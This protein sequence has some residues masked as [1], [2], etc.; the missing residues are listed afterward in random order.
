MVRATDVKLPSL[1]SWRTAKLLTQ[2]Q[3]ADKSGV[4][5]GTIVRAEHGAPVSLLSA[6]K[7]AQVLGVSVELLKREGERP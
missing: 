2:K 5:R 4:A 6:T 3:L 7:L 1:A